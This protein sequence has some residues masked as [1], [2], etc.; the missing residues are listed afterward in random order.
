MEDRDEW[1][2]QP[3]ALLAELEKVA[4]THKMDVKDPQWPKAANVL[5]RRL[6]EVQANLVDMGIKITTGGH[7]TRRSITIQRSTGNTVRTVRT[8]HSQQEQQVL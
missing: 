8:V 1:T 4:E 7:S 3:T 5:T 6:K 2:G